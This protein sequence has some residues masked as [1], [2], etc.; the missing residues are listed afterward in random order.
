MRCLLG[1][2]W[3][4]WC[5]DYYR[6][7]GDYRIQVS[8]LANL[9]RLSGIYFVPERSP[10]LIWNYLREVGPIGVWRKVASRLQERRRN[11][12]YMSFGTGVVVEAPVGAR[13]PAGTRVRFL[14]PGFPAC[15]ER[16]VLPELFMTEHSAEADA[17][18]SDAS[19]RH[20]PN[21]EVGVDLGGLD[22]ARS[23]SPYS[24][25][26]PSPEEGAR[27][28]ALI[29]E[30]DRA[31]DWSA[32]T[33][34]EAE[35]PSEIRELVSSEPRRESSTTPRDPRG[36]RRKRA[37]LF[38]YGHY[39]KTN[40]LPNVKRHIDVQA[41]HEVDPTQI[42]PDLAGAAGW[43]TSP[44]VRP[45]EDYEVFLIAGF[46]HTH[47]PLAVA[48]L[49]QGAF[50]VVEKPLTVDRDQL[51]RLLRAME[52]PHAGFFGCFHKR[53]SPLNDY[54]I[55]D[56]RQSPEQPIDYHCIVYEVPLPDFHWYRWQNSKSRLI[57]NG[58]HWID[59]FLYLNGYKEVESIELGASP[60]GTIHCSATLKNGAYFTMTLTEKGSP[61]I[62][63]QDYVEL[64]AGDITAQIINNS[65]YLAQGRTRVLRRVRVNKLGTYQ[66]MYRTIAEGIARGEGGDSIDSVRV[67]GKLV[68]DFE[69]ALNEREAVRAWA[70]R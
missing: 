47:A 32:A 39:A 53:Y 20:L 59:H 18:G 13:Y 30:L 67:S 65:S 52:N 64:R 29:P 37:V 4:D 34:L 31:L 33:R 42:P 57:S 12:K 25:S 69:D 60:A 24:G 40:I 21:A 61:R 17:E 50:A 15:V 49:E 38:G 35:V 6:A 11:E 58:C 19:V 22:G 5:L 48:A 45:G 54:A 10:R 26:G 1:E 56:L 8:A 44:H 9:E 55:L 2:E 63:L 62:G 7:P 51:D 23:W 16:V 41:I 36:R 27:I 66:D 68:L 46:H 28:A 14:A 3:D 43:D 70:A